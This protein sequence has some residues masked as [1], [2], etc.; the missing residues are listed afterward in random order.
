MYKRYYDI[1]V[2]AKAYA[3]R[4][5]KAGGRIPSNISQVSDFIKNQKNNNLWPNLIDAWFFRGVH[6]INFGNSTFSIKNTIQTTLMGGLTYG[7]D[8]QSGL[9]TNRTNSQYISTPYNLPSEYTIE[10]VYYISSFPSAS[11]LWGNEINDSTSAIGQG[12]WASFA[13]LSE[14]DIFVNGDIAQ[15]YAFNTNA[16]KPITRY[17][18]TQ[19]RTTSTCYMNGSFGSS[20]AFSY[21]KLGTVGTYFGAR[22]GN[23]GTGVQNITNGN[24]FAVLIYNK[25]LS[26]TEIS[27]N[28]NLTKGRVDV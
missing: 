26:A 27:N 1:D 4:I 5:V 28:Y 11:S 19:S 20:S 6:N 18:M 12:S 23:T 15:G 21:S 16:L 8:P 3:N 10:I 13:T 14:L 24:I 22:H 17:S 7:S 2:D 9:T 25:A